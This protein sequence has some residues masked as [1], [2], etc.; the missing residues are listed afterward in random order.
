MQFKLF[1]SRRGEPTDHVQGRNGYGYRKAFVFL[2]GEWSFV[3]LG[4]E[5]GTMALWWLR[6]PF[7]L[8]PT[9][10]ARQVN[11][12]NV[13]NARTPRAHIPNNPRTLVPR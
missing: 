8:R 11:F 2:V 3:F 13:C 10:L 4:L 9:W 5:T 7:G 1:P 6:R 12:W